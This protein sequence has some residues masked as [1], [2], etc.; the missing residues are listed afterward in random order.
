MPEKDKQK[1]YSLSKSVGQSYVAAEGIHFLR[2]EMR[3]GVVVV[4]FKLDAPM[5]DLA[6]GEGRWTHEFVL[7]RASTEAR[8]RNLRMAGYQAEVT[9]A[10][11]EAWP[12]SVSP[13]DETEPIKPIGEPKTTGR[14]AAGKPRGVEH[15][16]APRTSL[17]MHGR[18]S[19][20]EGVH[21]CV[22][23]DVSA[24]GAQL[25]LPASVEAPGLAMLHLPDGR[26]R[27]VMLRW[28]RETLAGFQFVDAANAGPSIVPAPRS[29]EKVPNA[30]WS[31]SWHRLSTALELSP[32]RV[33][34]YRPVS[35][36]ARGT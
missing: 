27:T 3:A 16:A 13:T 8:L 21:H 1:P 29:R 34:S 11:L 32:V 30:C 4:V 15:R 26:A 33:H 25:A 14:E 5:L 36:K 18:L 22:I 23:L 12:A 9:A 2:Y 31:R 6:T 24:T 7:D 35:H 19:W 28:Q 20:G 10:A 17:I